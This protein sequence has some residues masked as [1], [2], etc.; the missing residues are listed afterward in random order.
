M[1]LPA[2]I[3]CVVGAAGAEAALLSG[4]GVSAAGLESVGPLCWGRWNV[5]RVFQTQPV[6]PDNLV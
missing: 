4:C 5:L 2:R 3:G 6:E 1:W